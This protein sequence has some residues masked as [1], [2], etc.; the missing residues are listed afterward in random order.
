MALHL[1]DIFQW[2]SVH[3]DIAYHDATCLWL[4][5]CAALYSIGVVVAFESK[6]V[7][8]FTQHLIGQLALLF[9][10]AMQILDLLQFVV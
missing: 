9:D 1:A 7:L 4:R 8:N 10:L 3:C 5:E 2:F 6:F